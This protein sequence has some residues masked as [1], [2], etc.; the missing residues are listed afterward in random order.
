MVEIETL[1]YNVGTHDN[2][3]GIQQTFAKVIQIE[4]ERSLLSK[5]CIANEIGN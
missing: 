1:K 5:Q 2:Y 4:L 3:A